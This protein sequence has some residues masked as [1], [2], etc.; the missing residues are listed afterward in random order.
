MDWAR[1]NFETWPEIAE[2]NLSKWTAWVGVDI[3]LAITSAS[4]DLL[5]ESRS[6]P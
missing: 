3:C 6:A 4:I 2:S 1:R 5:H